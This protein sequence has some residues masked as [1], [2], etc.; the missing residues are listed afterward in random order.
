MRV[1]L[2]I[3]HYVDLGPDG[4]AN[5]S[6]GTKSCMWFEDFLCQEELPLHWSEEEEDDLNIIKFK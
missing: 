5:P 2:K 1:I 6:K 4:L 3:K